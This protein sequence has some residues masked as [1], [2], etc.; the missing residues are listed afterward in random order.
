VYVLIKKYYR[1]KVRADLI[2]KIKQASACIDIT[3][4]LT[5]DLS[6]ISKKSI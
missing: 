1:P 5:S 3:D 6:Y 2:E 4:G